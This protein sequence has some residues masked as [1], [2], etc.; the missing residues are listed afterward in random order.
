MALLAI[1]DLCLETYGLQRYTLE[2]C[3]RKGFKIAI[4]QG[5]KHS[6]YIL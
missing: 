2:I 3:N 5:R 1:L 6:V 4:K